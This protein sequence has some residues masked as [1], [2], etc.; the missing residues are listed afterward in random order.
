MVLT[1]QAARNRARAGRYPRRGIGSRLAVEHPKCLLRFGG[2]SLL[3]HHI[4]LLEHCNVPHLTLV[5]GHGAAQIERELTALSPRLEVATVYNPDY[6][7]GSI[8]SLWAARHVLSAGE[9]ILLMDADVLYDQRLLQAL[10]ASDHGNCF[11]LDRDYLPGEEPVKLCV[12]DH[13]LVEFRKRP[14]P[15]LQF[16][17]SG[18]SVGFFRFTAAMAR[19]L[20]GKAQAY[21]EQGRGHE[22]HEEALRDLLLENPEA[23]GFAD[24]TGLPWTE[25]DFPEDV[26]RAERHI[27]AQLLPLPEHPS[28]V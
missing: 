23:F 17:F 2:Q 13:R 14:D 18:E 8:I 1:P 4:A 19:R 27:L 16:D 7:Q 21:R 20:A 12:R 5:L 6:R 22:P 3:Q 15:A 24:V 28:G 25:I 26:A 10:I 9:D 11:L